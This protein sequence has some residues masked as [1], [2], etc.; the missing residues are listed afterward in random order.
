M[1]EDLGFFQA[2]KLIEVPVTVEKV[3]DTSFL[4]WAVKEL[5]PYKAK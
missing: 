5:G 1:K 4:D 3:V 2:Q